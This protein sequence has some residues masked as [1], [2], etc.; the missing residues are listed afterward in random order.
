MLCTK[1]S[2]DPHSKTE[3]GRWLYFAALGDTQPVSANDN[4]IYIIEFPLNQDIYGCDGVCAMF[5]FCGIRI[6]KIPMI[7]I[8]DKA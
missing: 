1:R 6:S 5:S 2:I 8:D 7:S 4:A 3:P